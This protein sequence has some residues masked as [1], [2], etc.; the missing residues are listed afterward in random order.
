MIR[1]PRLP[2]A[3]A[4]FATGAMTGAPPCCPGCCC[5]VCA[6]AMTSAMQRLRTRDDGSGTSCVLDQKSWPGAVA[7]AALWAVAVGGVGLACSKA[8]KH[9]TTGKRLP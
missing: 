7:A 9:T 3:P 6:T 5:S 2:S 4:E 8:A 1:T